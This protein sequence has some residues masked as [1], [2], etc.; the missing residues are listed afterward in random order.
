MLSTLMLAMVLSLPQEPCKIEDPTIPTVLSVENNY[1]RVPVYSQNPPSKSPKDEFLNRMLAPQKEKYG[2]S[3]KDSSPFKANVLFDP[4]KKQ[5][6]I[7]SIQ[8]SNNS[9]LK[10]IPSTW[11]KANLKNIP[12]T[13]EKMKEI[14]IDKNPKKK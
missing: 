2:L 10:P 12:L 7:P 3:V 4:P 14:E 1:Y 5:F 8:D 9:S 13:W 6:I 11:P